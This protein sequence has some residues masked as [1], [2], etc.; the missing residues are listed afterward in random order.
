[1]SRGS[2]RLGGGA[3]VA[4][5]LAVSAAGAVDYP[6]SVSVP[7]VRVS[8]E[9]ETTAAPQRG[10]L[11]LGLRFVLEPGWHIYWRHPGDSGLAP[12]VAW[13]LPAGMTAS[14]ILWPAPR[15]I[16]F[17]PL[18]NYG[19]EGEVLLP[20]SVDGPPREPGSVLD[21]GAQVRWLVCKEDCLPGSTTLGLRLPVVAGPLPL[22]PAAPA[23]A[24]ARAR[25][26]RPAESLGIRAVAEEHGTEIVLRL[27]LPR[28]N[29]PPR[30]PVEFFPT[31]G[32]V[33]AHAARQRVAYET[34]GTVVLALTPAAERATPLAW[35]R[36][37]VVAASGWGADGSA[38]AIRIEVPVRPATAT[39]RPPA[40][41]SPG[42]LAALGLAALGGGLLNLMPCVF[43]VLSIKVLDAVRRAG[44][45][46]KAARRHAAAYA[47]GVLVSMWA[48]AGLLVAL[49]AGGT[50]LGWGFQLQS[51][52]F[53]VAVAALLCVLALNLLGV[54]DLGI[55]LTAIEDPLGRSDRLAAAFVSGMVA[56]AVATPCT[57]PFMGTALAY[58][59][60]VPALPAFGIFTA[61]GLGFALPYAVLCA[62]PRWLR[63]LPRSGYWLVLLKQGLAFPLLG[64]VVWLVWV[65]AQQTGHQG[66]L[67]ALSTLL[68]VGLG[69][70]LA[71]QAER[72]VHRRPRMLL[73]AGALA[74]ACVALG[75]GMAGA[76]RAVVLAQG[77]GAAEGWVP[78]SAAELAAQ[79][80]AGRPV[81]V[82]FTAA[83]CLTCQV[84][85]RLVL[86]AQEVRERFAALGVALLRAD[87][88]RQSP[89]ITVALAAYGRNSVP[90]YVLYGPGVDSPP[91]ILPTV[92]TRGI[93]LEALNRLPQPKEERP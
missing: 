76:E 41:A 65:V 72:I 29:A 18:A 48:L 58:A 39:A 38:P 59:L 43:P 86:E 83:W 20:V 6:R 7:P 69:S 31:E 9:T 1:M 52:A 88:T 62:W 11:A 2:A 61:L 73:R 64:A 46:P 42:F 25:A 35:L 12:S 89:E 14:E 45:D 71:G 3:V 13:T 16:P 8:L 56:V 80:A 82:D 47:A 90:L 74:L 27:A 78:F 84:N 66:V 37:V 70:W 63:W 81:F 51:P 44:G 92:L 77:A 34:D 68:A 15:R 53:V 28:P 85:E 30:G 10:P 87:W 50:Q 24:A 75:G 33:I 17:G 79:R 32:G 93:V 21:L 49:R 67:V 91:E 36:G 55:G 5:A 54:F 60:T 22:A 23:F 19:Y 40:V 26:E 4:L 57:A